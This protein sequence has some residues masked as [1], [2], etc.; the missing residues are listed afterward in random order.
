MSK[1]IAKS[2]D[3]LANALYT[4]GVNFIM[5]GTNNDESLH[6]QPARLITALVQNSEARLRLSLDPHN[7]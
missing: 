5:G 3:Q 1:I 7:R 4:L 6:K 2:S